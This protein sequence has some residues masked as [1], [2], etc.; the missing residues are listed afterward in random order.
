MLWRCI[1]LTSRRHQ[2]DIDLEIAGAS[3]IVTPPIPTWLP[4][5]CAAIS[6]VFSGGPTLLKPSDYRWSLPLLKKGRT[7]PD[8]FH[9]L[10]VEHVDFPAPWSG[11]IAAFL[12]AQMT[13]SD[14]VSPS[15]ARRFPFAEHL[16]EGLSGFARS[17]AP[18]GVS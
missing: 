7:E 10:V 9:W 8:N 17:Q 13:P 3:P 4:V 12:D 1:P 11:F 18:P 14:W 5:L 16:V 2:P 15:P 6:D